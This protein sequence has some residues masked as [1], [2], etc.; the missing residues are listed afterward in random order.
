VQG[1]GRFAGAT[2]DIF[3]AGRALADGSFINEVRGEICIP[4]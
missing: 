3:T 1:T 2:G 4:K